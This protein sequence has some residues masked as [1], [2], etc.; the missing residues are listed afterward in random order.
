[1]AWDYEDLFDVTDLGGLTPIEQ[2]ARLE[3]ADR[4][5]EER[6]G[7]RKGRM[8]YRTRT[9]KA[10]P[11]L[12]AEI[13]PI[14]GTEMETKARAARENLTPEKIQRHN[15]EKAR[16]NLVRLLDANFSQGDYHITLTFAGKAPGW[17]RAVKDIR[18]FIAKV[19][20]LREK[21]GLPEMKYI[22]AM[23]DAEEGREKRIHA[24]LITQGDL[25]REDLEKLWA[26]NGKTIG[27]CNCDELQPGPEGLEA[28][29]RYIY[30]QRPGL[31]REKKG[32]RKYSCSKNLRKPQLRTSDT[33]V[34]GGRVK[35]LAGV[36][37]SDETE[38][39]R[40]MEKLY[41]GYEYVR[42]SAK[43]S[44]IVDGVYIRVL[45]RK[46]RTER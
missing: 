13:F 28:I 2:A 16:R 1:M 3:A 20:R 23:E 4:W 29:A 26:K 5:K 27:Y 14:F 11:R 15:D 37:G 36:F 39:R 17:N 9:V 38:A 33:K 21:R 24:H 19:R 41:P 32:K 10:G 25:P 30:N 18:N 8:G 45:M 31:P 43:G 44:D 6:T 7:I 34:T 12:E 22:Y 42:G 46:R 35:R 40:I